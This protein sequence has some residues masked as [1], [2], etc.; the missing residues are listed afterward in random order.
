MATNTLYNIHTFDDGN[1]KYRD[2]PNEWV[3]V[4]TMFDGG[5]VTLQNQAYPEIIIKS[6]SSWKIIN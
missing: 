5:K 1:D 6:I 3:I 2:F 4:E